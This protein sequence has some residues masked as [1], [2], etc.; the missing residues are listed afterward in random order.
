MTLINVLEF[1]TCALIGLSIPFFAILLVGRSMKTLDNMFDESMDVFQ[2]SDEP[3]T[4]EFS[5][6]TTITWE[7]LSQCKA[8]KEGY[9][10]FYKDGVK[11]YVT[12]G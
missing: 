9:L 3:C 11:H 12:W 6:Q 2:K 5:P 8:D 4:K 1:I 7:Q 10:Y